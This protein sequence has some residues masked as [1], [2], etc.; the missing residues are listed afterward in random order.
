MPLTDEDIVRDLLHRGTPQ[1]NLPVSMATE[2][3]A[4]QPRRDRRGRIVSVAATGVALGT[5]AGVVALAPGHS[6]A[7]GHAVQITNPASPARPALKLTA[8]QRVLGRLSS[9][10]AGQP[11]GRGRYVVMTTEGSDN[12]VINVKNTAVLDGLT[13][14][15]R[16]DQ[17]GSDGLPSG[18][19]SVSRHFSPTAAQFAGHAHRADRTARRSHRP[20]GR[21]ESAN[22]WKRPE[23]AREAPAPLRV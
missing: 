19:G 14:D 6:G 7:P 12:G 18:A 8:A 16:E 22:G 20:V 23:A 17:K 9:A 1:L 3:V 21:P 15:L 13:G 2:V 11:A 4:R 10:A 5:A